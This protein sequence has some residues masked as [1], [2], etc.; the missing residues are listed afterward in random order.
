[1]INQ[2]LYTLLAVAET[3]SITKAAEM[4]HLTQPAVSQQIKMIETE[5]GCRI[6]QHSDGMMKITEEGEVIV[7][8]AKRIQALYNRCRQDLADMKTTNR[9]IV[10]GITRTAEM[11]GLGEMLAEYGSNNPGTHIKIYTGS[12]I[13]LYNLLRNYEADL[14]IVEGNISDNTL[15]K[16][17]LDTDEL[18]LAMSPDNPLSQKEH[19]TLDDLKKEK[20]ILRLNTSGTRMLFEETLKQHS[21]SI[22]NFN[23]ILEVNSI[24]TIKDLVKTNSGVSIMGHALCLDDV[25]KNSMKLRTIDGLQMKREINL[26]YNPDFPHR[27]ILN[28]ITALYS[29]MKNRLN[30]E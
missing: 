27:D 18:V 1:M 29:E 11:S 25:R 4:M 7:N 17:H 13:N 20:L 21:E 10:L 6:F 24:G 26:V 23:V 12:I 3:K 8:A 15:C 16:I 5:F 30:N 14:I 9:H 2:R 28:S 19:I 22:D